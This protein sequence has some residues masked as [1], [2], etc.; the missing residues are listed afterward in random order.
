MVAKRGGKDKTKKELHRVPDEDRSFL[1][2]IYEK[3]QASEPEP[4]VSKKRENEPV[5]KAEDI[6]FNLDDGEEN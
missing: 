4:K 2:S 3:E 1:M 6:E 5:I